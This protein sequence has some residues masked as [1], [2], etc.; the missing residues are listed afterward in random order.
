MNTRQQPYGASPHGASWGDTPW[1]EAYHLPGA[2]ELGLSKKLLQRYEWWHFEPHQDWVDPSG[3][4]E[5]VDLPF[6]AGIPGKVRIIYFY[7]PGFPWMSRPIVV[8]NIEPEISYHAF[9]WN[10]RIGKEHPLGI[11]NPD[12]DGSWEVPLQ[13]TLSD[14]GLVLEAK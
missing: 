2:I 12:A 3:S 4:T 8:K 7:S 14:W 5:N 1:E 6:A 11:I 13:P 10:P 9:F